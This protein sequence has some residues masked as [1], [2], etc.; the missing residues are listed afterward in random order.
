METCQSQFTFQEAGSSVA[1]T[2]RMLKNLSELK[3]S[4]EQTAEVV[5]SHGK[6]LLEL[7][8]KT[9]ASKNKSSGPWLTPGNHRR[10]QTTEAVMTLNRTPR[11]KRKMAATNSSVE[12]PAGTPRLGRLAVA[13][14]TDGTSN[15]DEESDRFVAKPLHRASSLDFLDSNGTDSLQED[16][17]SPGSSRLLVTPRKTGFKSSLSVPSVSPSNQDEMMIEGV[18]HQMDG[19]LEQLRDVC[20]RQQR[21]L[22]QSL[23]VA[24]FREAVPE[25]TEWVEQVGN[26]FLREKHNLGRSIEEVGVTSYKYI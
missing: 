5:Q 26:K 8:I 3:S 11:S 12:S 1:D 24:E 16:T 7:V 13:E 6:K 22:K 20:E 4:I 10:S 9:T 23:K 18:L 19:N 15:G 21:R 17:E 2:E 14:S 25:V